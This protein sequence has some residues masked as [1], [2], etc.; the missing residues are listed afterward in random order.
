[1]KNLIQ[2]NL[3]AALMLLSISISAQT[4]VRG[5]VTDAATGEPLPFANVVFV[6][7]TVGTITNPEG[8]YN[9]QT[10]Q[11]CDSISFSMLGYDTYTVAIK[12]NTYQEINVELGQSDMVLNEIVIRPG[13]NPAWRIMRNVEAN[14]KK[15]NPDRL[16]GYQY[17]CYNKM[18][19]DLSNVSP[20]M[21]EKGIMKNFDFVMNYAD[22]S[23]ETGK[24]YLPVFIT[25]TMSDVYYKSSPSKKKEV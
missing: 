18:E 6:G 12:P 19:I 9:M 13:E 20:S 4:K 2:I 5:L 16:D 7:T 8:V 25:E 22:T 1:M 17:E 21:T 3:L 10:N 15:N 23:A 24:V 11:K 14:R